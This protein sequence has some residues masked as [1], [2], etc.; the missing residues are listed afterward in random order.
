MPVKVGQYV[1]EI[2][3]V[4]SVG[5]E[6]LPELWGSFFVRWKA[7]QA[8]CSLREVIQERLE[9]VWSDV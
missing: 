5:L 3:E 1:L 8:R 2:L 9:H 4:L 7:P 6:H